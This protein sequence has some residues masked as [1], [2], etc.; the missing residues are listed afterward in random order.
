MSSGLSPSAQ[1]TLQHLERALSKT[2]HEWAAVQSWLETFYPYQ[3]EWLLDWSRFAV[4]VKSRQIGASHT[5]AGAAVLWGLLGETTTVI[6]LGE[7][8]ATEVVEK[9]KLHAQAL[10]KLGSRWARVTQKSAEQVKLSS[11]G[12]ILALP[13]TS[14]GRSYSGNVILDEFAYYQRPRQVWDGAGG[15]VLHGY[16]LR[17]LSTPNGIGNLFHQIYTDPGI[18]DGYTLHK[19]TLDEARE[20]GLS[21][22]LDDCWKQARGDPRVFDQLFRC[23]FLDDAEQYL[24]TDIVLR[25][26]VPALPRTLRGDRY[27]GLDVGLSNDLTVLTVVEQDEKGVAHLVDLEE[28]K[29]TS[30]EEQ[31]AMIERSASLW[32]WKRIC[33]DSTGLGAVP[34][35]LLQSKLG[36]QRVEPVPFTL[37]SKEALA[38]LLY[39]AFNDG[40]VKMLR[41]VPLINDLCSLRRLITTTG[42]VRYDAPRTAAGHADRAWSLALA[43][44][45]CS[46]RPAGVVALGDGDFGNP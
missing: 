27:A 6:S 3:L 34:S 8:E 29:R 1:R 46:T 5:Y 14:G 15:T 19:V 4:T 20:Q 36:R 7:R 9:A 16:K 31:Q 12:R 35:Q 13:A 44:H 38:T 39:Q 33:V 24:P 18:N 2:P 45:A 30:W 21:V 43:L 11:G 23:S 22:N 42:A 37:Q 32:G 40:M 10:N 26:V 25:A 28:C 41:D 17:V